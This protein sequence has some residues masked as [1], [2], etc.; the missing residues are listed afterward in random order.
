MRINITKEE[1]GEISRAQIAEGFKGKALVAF[2]DLLGFRSEILSKWSDE[3]NDPLERLMVFKNFNDVAK[4]RAIY[5][6]FQ[7][8]D[9]NLIISVPFPD[10]MT[11]SDSFIFI[12][13]LIGESPDEILASILAISGSILNLWEI[14][15]DHGFT[16]RGCIDYGEIYYNANDLVGPSLITTYELESKIAM[17]SRVLYTND[18]LK[19][20]YPNL[21]KAQVAL[22]EYYKRYLTRD[23]DERIILNPI[24]IYGYNNEEGTQRG[25]DKL[26]E[27]RNNI[28]KPALKAKYNN[29]IFRLVNQTDPDN[30]FDIFKLA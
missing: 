20:I 29:L 7:D 9:G 30:D 21:E 1:L 13:P 16:I 22:K 23:V 18:V 6:D 27:M 25:V 19:L 11:F 14:C 2:I 8:Y 26:I 28:D 5:H 24:V 4:K 12:L 17:T 3:D 10:T 15:I